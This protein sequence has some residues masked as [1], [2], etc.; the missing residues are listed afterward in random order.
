MDDQLCD[1]G[2][3]V[4]SQDKEDSSSGTCE[5]PQSDQVSTS[6]EYPCYTSTE[7]K[8]LCRGQLKYGGYG[9]TVV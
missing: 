8:D 4:L 6:C 1:I 3:L 7:Y 5:A 9:D 2:A